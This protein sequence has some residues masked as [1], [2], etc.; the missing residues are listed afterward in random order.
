VTICTHDRKLCFGDILNGCL[1]ETKQSEICMDCWADLSNHYG[2]CTSDE[3]VVMPNHVH[4]IIIID[5]AQ[6]RETGLKPVSTKEKRYSL[7]EIV[8]GFKTFSARKI[9]QQQGKPGR[10]FWQQRY[11]DHIIRDE[12]EYLRILQYI[13][14]NPAKWQEDKNS[15]ENLYM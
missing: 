4:G 2:N 5:N 10:P 11:Y 3:F 6:H 9:N 8:R 1:A 7:S 12:D 14:D 15:I 13:V